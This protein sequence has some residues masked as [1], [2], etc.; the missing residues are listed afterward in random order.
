MQINEDVD[1]LTRRSM[2]YN[3]TREALDVILGQEAEDTTLNTEFIKTVRV[4]QQRLLLSK[5]KA[6]FFKLLVMQMPQLNMK[7]VN[8]TGHSVST[9]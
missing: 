6:V 3:T 1:F 7:T 5:L 4:T 9:T 2:C 8:V